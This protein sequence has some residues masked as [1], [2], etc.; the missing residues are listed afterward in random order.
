MH[1]FCVAFIPDEADFNSVWVEFIRIQSELG[2]FNSGWVD[3]NPGE[4]YLNL[5]MT[6]SNPGA[7]G[8]NSTEADFDSG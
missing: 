4:A 6:A 7:A 3:L 5:R 2:D 8:I 1:S